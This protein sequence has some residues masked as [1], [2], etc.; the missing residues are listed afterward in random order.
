MYTGGTR[1][2]DRDTSGR[3]SGTLKKIFNKQEKSVIRP[4]C[5]KFTPLQAAP[6]QRERDKIPI[7]KISIWEGRGRPA[8]NDYTKRRR[9]EKQKRN[10]VVPYYGLFF[11]PGQSRATIFCLPSSRSPV[12][13]RWFFS[14]HRLLVRRNFYYRS[15]S[16][17]FFFLLFEFIR[18]Y[19]V[20]SFRCV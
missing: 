12:F 2:N 16:L 6:T 13:F 4:S 9:S 15:S 11:A 20:L 1:P 17:L 19:S 8:E 3:E 5:Y 7:T 10:T 18:I 14:C